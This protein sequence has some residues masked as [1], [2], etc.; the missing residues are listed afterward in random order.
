MPGCRRRDTRGDRQKLCGQRRDRLGG[1]FGSF[2]W[3]RRPPR[4]SP[5]SKEFGPTAAGCCRS[6]TDASGRS[7]SSTRSSRFHFFCSRPGR[8]PGSDR[9]PARLVALGI[10][11]AIGG[12]SSRRACRAIRQRRSARTIRAGAGCILDARPAGRTRGGLS[13]LKPF[14]STS[15]PPGRRRPGAARVAKYPWVAFDALNPPSSSPTGG[16]QKTRRIGIV[17]LFQCV[18]L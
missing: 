9:Q 5:I 14:V 2:C 8:P 7:E 6:F 3:V 18:V 11:C 12:M 10:G 13:D 17:T 4:T 1:I 16:P 15:S